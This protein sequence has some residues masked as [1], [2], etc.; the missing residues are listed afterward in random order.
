MQSK[1]SVI[2]PVYNQE[3]FIGD[4]LDAVLMQDLEDIEVLCVNDGSTDQSLAILRRYACKDSRLVIIDQSNQGVAA[5]RNI[6]IENASGEYL[7]FLDPD[8]YYPNSGVLRKLYNAA[9]NNNALVSAGSFSIFD[10]EKN[11]IIYQFSD[12]LYGYTFS[13]EGFVSYSEYQFDYGFMRFLFKTDFLR[14]NNLLFPHYIRFQDPPFLV[15][16]LYKAQKFYAISDIVYRYRLGHQSFEWS[17]DRQL[18]LLAGMADN[19]R[20]SKEKK[21]AKLHQL[22]LM[23]LECEYGGVFYWAIEEPEI[24]SALVRI[25][26]LIDI[27]LVSK[28]YLFTGMVGDSYLIKPLRQQIL[29]GEKW[30]KDISD[31]QT[32]VLAERKDKES[33]WKELDEIKS[34]LPVKIALK[35][36]K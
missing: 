27:D 21:L 17:I 3:A 30:R 28:E 10:E 4:C 34:Y 12:M 25:N 22:T 6:G 9:A 36:K 14:G 31:L 29:N 7:I 8:D 33:A 13:K 11:E 5:A 15:K 16:A 19:L 32:A 20:Y 1:V 24:F 18:A 2:I 23:R 26:S 35:I